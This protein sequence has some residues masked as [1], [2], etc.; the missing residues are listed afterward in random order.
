MPPFLAGPLARARSVLSSVSLGQ[1]VVIGLLTVGLL[2]GGIFFYKWVTAPTYAPLFSNLASSDA[3]AIVTELGTEGVP[4]QLSDGGATILVPQ[5]QV[6]GVRLTLSGKGLPASQDTGYSLLDQQGI[7]TSEFQQQ[8]TYQRAVEGELEKTLEAIKGVNT[9]VV[10]IAMPK[11]QVFTDDQGKPT[12]SVLL[13]LAPATQLTAQQVQA[14]TN[15][16]SSSIEGMA[17]NDVTVADS[18]GNV[19]SAAGSGITA[20][21]GDTRTQLEQQKDD[22]LAGQAQALLNQ[23]LGPGHAMVSV[24]ANLDLSQKNSTSETYQYNKGTPPVS[25]STST[26]TYSGT[27]SAVGGV[28][29]NVSNGTA[30]SS[31]GNSSYKKTDSTSDNSVDKTTTTTQVAPGDITRMTVSVVM[32][33]TVA[34][35]VNLQ[36]VQSLV[37]N[38]VGLDPTRGDAITV[39]TMP[40]SNAAAKQAAA[41]IAAARK[42]QQQAQMF[43]L[44]KTGGIGLGIVLVVLLV[45]LRSRRRGGVEEEYEP[46]ELS[47]DML[48]ELDRLRVQST[49]EVIDPIDRE[50]LE[51]EAAE[52]QRVRGEI[53]QMVSERPDEVAAMLRGWLSEAKSGS[54]A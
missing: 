20:A 47:D 30:G 26:E 19:L 39:A 27:G 24:H 22:Q 45:W 3:S 29:G 35:N 54:A 13:D 14:V 16:V 41:E 1:K 37:G 51:A 52:R 12:A 32:D 17:P 43:S 48:E 28:L 49:R 7:T 36:Q 40:F 23:I 31:G 44:I 21:A 15:L 25:Q 9:A 38:A 4:Y 6:A 2:L 50:A 5:S 33:G 8:V 11:D 42:A 46:L 18:N 10:H 34:G 53:S